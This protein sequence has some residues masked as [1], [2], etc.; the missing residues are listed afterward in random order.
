MQ[1][2]DRVEI[3]RG[4]AKMLIGTVISTKGRKV[5]VKTDTIQW[6]RNSFILKSRS[7]RKI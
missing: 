5:L 1:I 6:G 7:V 2:G 3:K 4:F